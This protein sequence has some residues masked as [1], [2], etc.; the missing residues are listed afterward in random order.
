M[1]LVTYCKTAFTAMNKVWLLL[2]LAITPLVQA[3]EDVAIDQIA[4]VVNDDSVLMGE[5]QQRL[6]ARQLSLRQDVDE[7]VL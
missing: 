5:A 4:A 6:N 2:V 7:V 3:A 1:A